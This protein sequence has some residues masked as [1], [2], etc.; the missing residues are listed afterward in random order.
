MTDKKIVALPTFATRA[1]EETVKRLEDLL[2][3]AKAGRITSIAYACT[4]ATDEALTGFT[5]TPNVHLQI[6]SLAI[7]QH[8]IIGERQQLDD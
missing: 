1:N 7:L 2:E 8:R 5:S 3:Q 6:S 4:L